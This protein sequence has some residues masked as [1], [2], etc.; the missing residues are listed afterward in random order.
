MQHQGTKPALQPMVGRRDRGLP[1]QDRA[2]HGHGQ[3]PG[4]SIYRGLGAL[5]YDF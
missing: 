3:D 2:D 1:W 5:K 4:N